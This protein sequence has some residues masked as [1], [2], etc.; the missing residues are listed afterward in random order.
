[1]QESG[2]GS[3]P[4]PVAGM[5]KALSPNGLSFAKAL[6][7]LLGSGMIESALG[8]WIELGDLTQAAA[9]WHGSG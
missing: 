3:A 4:R 7:D 8:Y 1:M 9:L 2:L 5:Q 6:C